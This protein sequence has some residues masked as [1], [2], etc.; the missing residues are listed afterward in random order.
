[1]LGQILGFFPAQLLWL[2][3]VSYSIATLVEYIIGSRGPHPDPP[4]LRVQFLPRLIGTVGGIIGGWIFSR[5]FGV[6]TPQPAITGD[7]AAS[8][9]TGV[10]IGVILALDIYHLAVGR[11]RQL[12]KGPQ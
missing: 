2:L 12:S 3:L 11:G 5:A 9:A 8:I 1:V 4:P 10:F 6:P 7:Q